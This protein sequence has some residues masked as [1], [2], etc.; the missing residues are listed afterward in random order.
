MIDRGEAEE[1]KM[2]LIYI[3]RG[4]N[5]LNTKVCSCSVK[6]AKLTMFSACGFVF[7]EVSSLQILT[8]FRISENALSMGLKRGDFFLAL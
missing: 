4:G 3:K 5:K 7:V 6:F 8:I 2:I 1:N